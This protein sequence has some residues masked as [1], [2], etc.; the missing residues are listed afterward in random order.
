MKEMF[1]CFNIFLKKKRNLLHSRL[2]FVTSNLLYIKY[3]NSNFIIYTNLCTL[4]I[5]SNTF[6]YNSSHQRLFYSSLFSDLRLIMENDT[7]NPSS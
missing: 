3:I 1:E 4:A 6:F 5:F 7:V 2:I